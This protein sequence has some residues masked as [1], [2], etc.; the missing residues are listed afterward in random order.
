L[1]ADRKE[2]GEKAGFPSP[3]RK[4]S[5]A[6]VAWP[7][8]SLGVREVRFLLFGANGGQPLHFDHLHGN[9]RL[10]KWCASS[11]RQASSSMFR[12]VMRS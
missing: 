4:G 11:L 2:N 7:N 8:P 3:E 6:V 5:A 1:T 10:L 12:M 9:L